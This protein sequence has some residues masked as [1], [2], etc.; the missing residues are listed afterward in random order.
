M[1]DIIKAQALP[2]LFPAKI[3]QDKSKKQAINTITN[4]IKLATLMLGELQRYDPCSQCNSSRALLQTLAW[5]AANP[6]FPPAESSDGPFM[7]T[8]QALYEN[9]KILGT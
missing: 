7:N 4:Y 9:G 1:E 3:A 8:V 6:A 2:N 5:F